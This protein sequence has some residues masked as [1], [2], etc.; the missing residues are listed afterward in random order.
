MECASNQI[1]DESHWFMFATSVTV[2]YK[3][4]IYVFAPLRS[5]V[6][7]SWTRAKM[8]QNWNKLWRGAEMDPEDDEKIDPVRLY[9][10]FN[11]HVTLTFRRVDKILL[12]FLT[13]LWVDVHLYRQH[14]LRENNVN[15]DSR[16][17]WMLGPTQTALFWS[18]RIIFLY[19]LTTLH[20][21][22]KQRCCSPDLILG[23]LKLVSKVFMVF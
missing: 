22:Q 7:L 23:L 8:S 14:P 5:I 3:C 12:Y 17:G 18:G 1:Q 10:D 6:W 16:C 19:H 13:L 9:G 11:G 2:K 15:Y 20:Q 21:V 4:T